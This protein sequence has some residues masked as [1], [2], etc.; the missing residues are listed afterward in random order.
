MAATL[1]PVTEDIL[2]C[3]QLSLVYLLLLASVSVYIYIFMSTTLF[4]LLNNIIDL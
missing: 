3:P 2:D 4:F 1:R